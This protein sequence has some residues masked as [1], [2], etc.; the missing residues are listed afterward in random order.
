VAADGGPTRRTGLLG[1]RH[2]RV[3]GLRAGTLEAPAR[4]F[5]ARTAAAPGVTIW[6][7]HRCA[8]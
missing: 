2:G 3:W 4:I 1:R 5:V 6:L 8:A 7:R